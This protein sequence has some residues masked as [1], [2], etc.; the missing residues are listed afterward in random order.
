VTIP[1][2]F[3]TIGVG[4]PILLLLHGLGANGEVW[5]NFLSSLK[6]P[7]SIVVPDFRGHGRSPWAETYSDELNAADI[8]AILAPNDET[9]VLGHSMGGVVGLVLANG[10]YNVNLKAVFT[11]GTKVEWS[12]EELAGLKRYAQSPPKQFATEQEARERFIKTAGLAGLFEPSASV[13]NA[14]VQGDTAP[15]RLSADPRTVLVVGNALLADV[16]RA[17]KAEKRLACGAND[18]LVELRQLRAI[19]AEAEYLGPFGHN[20]HVESPRRLLEHVPFLR[21]TA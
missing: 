7:G 16:F 11:F 19:D 13:V 10:N 4:A 20:V 15:Y 12:E 21:K 6:W 2:Y 18:P 17:C 3:R 5:A 14:G 9:Y 8:A 1:I